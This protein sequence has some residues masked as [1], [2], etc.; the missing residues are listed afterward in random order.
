[1]Y[2]S[3]SEGRIHYGTALAVVGA[4]IALAALVSLI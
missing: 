1:M 3:F 4:V 2:D